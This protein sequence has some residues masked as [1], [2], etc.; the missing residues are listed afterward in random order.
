VHEDHRV[1]VALAAAFA[2]V[3]QVQHLAGERMAECVSTAVD[4]DQ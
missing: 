3:E 2:G 4:A 1:G